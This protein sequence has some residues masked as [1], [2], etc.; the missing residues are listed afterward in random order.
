MLES[1]QIWL[2]PISNVNDPKEFSNWEL[3]YVMGKNEITVKEWDEI[4][5]SISEESKRIS[6]IAC[7]T[8]DILTRHQ[9]PISRY[10]EFGCIGR[11]FANSPMW[12]FYGEKHTGCCLMFYKNG[13][14]QEFNNQTK[15]HLS[16][17]NSILYVDEKFPRNIGFE[18]YFFE[19]DEVVEKGVSAYTKEFLSSRHKD[20]YFKKQSV[21]SYENEYRM[22]VMDDNDLPFKLNYGNSLSYICFGVECDES[23]KAEIKHYSRK[24]GFSSQEIKFKN[25]TIQM[26]M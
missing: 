14:I 25:H 1:G 15:G 11:G 16:Y 19:I 20:L 3:S 8:E 12:H 5:E 4:S 18:P 26:V 2:N 10:V 13:L 22:Y 7:F 21:W 9:M 23:K 24:R 6:K 17:H